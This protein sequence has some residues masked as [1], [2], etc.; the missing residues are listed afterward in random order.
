[1]IRPIAEGGMAVVWGGLHGAELPVA[2]KVLT[3][4]DLRAPMVRSVFRNEVRAVAKL[5]HPGIISIL[6]FGEVSAEAAAASKGRLQEGSPYLVMEYAT[7]GALGKR[8]RRWSWTALRR[9]LLAL[10]D[11]LAHAHSRGVIHRDLKP[12]NI[13]LAGPDDLRGGIK[14]TDFGIAWVGGG[15]D[16]QALAGTVQY[17]APEQHS[18]DF[19]NYG[20]WTDL[21]A[22]GCVAWRYAT[23]RTPFAHAGRAVARAHVFERPPAFVARFP[24]PDGF[25]AWLLTLLHKDP[26]ARY[27]SAA[28][29][30]T[31]L[32]GLSSLLD[33]PTLAEDLGDQEEDDP[34]ITDAA[35]SD[36]P[37][38]VPTSTGR[39]IS[40]EPAPTTVTML[41]PDWRA[42]QTWRPAARLRGA[43]LGLFALREI[44]L[45]GRHRQRDML[46]RGLLGIEEEGRPRI[47]W[48][49][50]A[51][52]VGKTRLVQWIAQR[53]NE[54][55]GVN[56]LWIN[57][58]NI[59]AGVAVQLGVEQ[60]VSDRLLVE[61]VAEQLGERLKRSGGA[62]HLLPALLAGLSPDGPSDLAEF[63][64]AVLR[65]IEL[66]SQQRPAILVI[67]DAQD[68]DESL[69]FARQV[70]DI[71]DLSEG[72]RAI[73]VVIIARDDGLA[74][75]PDTEQRITE[76][77]QLARA[78][79]LKLGPLE[80]S[81]RHEL[82][83]YLGL[84][85]ALA[86]RV[87][88]RS[89]GNP[90]FAVQLVDDWIHRGLLEAGSDGFVLA[91]GE[92]EPPIP[93][94]IHEVWAGR[95]KRILQ[96]LPGIAAIHLERAAAFGMEVE[97]AEWD[98]ACDDPNHRRVSEA[99][100]RM[101]RQLVDRLVEASFV[102]DWP[103]GFRFS[104][105]MLRESVERISRAAGRWHSHHEAIATLLDSAES[106][107]SA[108]VGVH[109][110]AAGD[111]HGAIDPLL[112]GLELWLQRGGA[113]QIRAGLIPLER[114]MR[115]AEIADD[116]PRWVS[117]WCRQ[118][119]VTRI[120]GNMREAQAQAER[121]RSLAER[122]G[123]EE[124]WSEATR[125]LARILQEEGDL[126][127]A[128]QTLQKAVARLLRAN[129]RGRELA[130]VLTRMAIIGRMMNQLDDA[131]RWASQAAGVLARAGIEDPAN[132]GYLIGELAVLA[133]RRGQYERAIELFRDAIPLLRAAVAPLR[134]AEVENN[135]GDAC[136]NLGRWGEAESAFLEA[137]RLLESTGS[138]P[139][140]PK[141]NLAICRIEAGRWEE[142]RKVA[143]DATHGGS[144]VNTALA[145]LARAVC[146]AA[147]GDRMA[148]GRSLGP[149]LESLRRAKYVDP[150]A[151]WLAERG[152]DR[153]Q[154]ISAFDSAITF[155][156]FAR[157]Q[158]AA[159]N[160]DE[161]VN[162]IS[163]VIAG[164]DVRKRRG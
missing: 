110:L 96:S 34:N 18:D 102:E 119:M 163:R 11:A 139:D 75:R 84:A 21:Y 76:L 131:E 49:R 23:G 132:E 31:A 124:L 78:K 42:P 146:D 153:A 137:I 60:L 58:D 62:E 43:G 155:G 92:E 111:P 8:K 46:W 65:L 89:R 109:R 57:G 120:R 127:G 44:P 88:E 36:S 152:C 86:A 158:Y 129:A 105:P 133:T 41:S 73:L 19:A 122:I 128:L 83:E 94:E 37:V 142:A 53:A 134:L 162:R 6:D 48:V 115:E 103:G 77:T 56:T 66:R 149:A 91:E 13:L 32:N 85:G 154:A 164:L 24:V 143:D 17:M 25:E 69:T 95:I 135:R 151:A 55:A 90:Q 147:M 125:E 126:P 47:V 82:L 80:P 10:L 113:P 15:K 2:V 68:A 52:G 130:V 28:D 79:V 22:L 104:H 81:E 144:K 114:A 72:R 4:G 112:D 98:I 138:N 5:N 87:D 108:R 3:G 136:K 157:E 116:D 33:D 67:D 27:T 117:L 39:A 61:E 159:L 9:L 106:R 51:S 150:D 59:A 160:N 1:M 63:H 40:D 54:I 100:Q 30:K 97:W 148:V 35:G 14:L 50:G 26:F 16:L 12:G 101:R 93:D 45:F 141:I 74:E 29:A 64:R 145:T 123:D 71:S 161:G 140:I 20:P 156:Y 7:G 99:G 107:D 118:A 70:A 38:P 121:A